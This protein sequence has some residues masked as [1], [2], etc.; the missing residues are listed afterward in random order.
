MNDTITENGLLP[1][2][3]IFGIIPC[4]PITSNDLSN[5]KLDA[6]KTAQVK[7]NSIFAETGV[8]EALTKISRLL[9]IE[10]I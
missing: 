10:Y 1:Y 7:M 8:L 5:K 6:M 9:L 2:R 3:L 4:F